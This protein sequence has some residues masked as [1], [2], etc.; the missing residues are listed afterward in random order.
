MIKHA[1]KKYPDVMEGLICWGELVIKK[2]KEAPIESE[3]IETE[4]SI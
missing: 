1:I 2:A 3:K 4:T